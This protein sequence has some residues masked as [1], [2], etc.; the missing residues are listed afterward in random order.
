MNILGYDTVKM[1]QTE[2]EVEAAYKLV[3]ENKNEAATD[4]VITVCKWQKESFSMSD[5]K[6]K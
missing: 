4:K 1:P 5:G 2:T 6:K 3:V